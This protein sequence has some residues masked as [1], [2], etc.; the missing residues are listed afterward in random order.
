MVSSSGIE[1]CPDA[2]R[3][4]CLMSVEAVLAELLVELGSYEFYIVREYFYLSLT[5]AVILNGK[6][7]KN[8]FL[9]C[10]FICLWDDNKLVI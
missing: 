6:L 5:H 1:L 9:Q 4:S 10:T 8:N 2:N 7:G 3:F